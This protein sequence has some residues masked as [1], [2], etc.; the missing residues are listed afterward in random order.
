MTT[1]SNNTRQT[2]KS[3][4]SKRDEVLSI[5]GCKYFSAKQVEYFC[6]KEGKN[7]VV[8][9][10]CA[11]EDIEE[12]LLYQETVPSNKRY[13]YEVMGAKNPMYEVYDV[14]FDFEVYGRTS[15]ED[16]WKKFLDAYKIFTEYYNLNQ[17]CAWRIVDASS[18]KKVSLHI[19]NR[20]KCF[21]NREHMLKHLHAFRDVCK[22]KHIDIGIDW[23]TSSRTNGLMRIIGSSKYGQTRPLVRASFHPESVEA[24][25]RE[26]FITNI[27]RDC[28]FNKKLKPIFEEE[29]KFESSSQETIRPSLNYSEDF[30]QIV[31]KF[32]SENLGSENFTHSRVLDSKGFL[33]LIR[34]RPSQCFLRKEKR[35]HD[36]LGGYIWENKGCVYYGC[37]C[38]PLNS[39]GEKCKFLISSSSS[40]HDENRDENE[41]ENNT[42]TNST[43]N[44]STLK[45]NSNKNLIKNIL[46][47]TPIIFKFF[48]SQKSQLFKINS[49]FISKNIP[50]IEEYL[51]EYKFICFKSN[52]NTGKTYFLFTLFPKYEKILVITFRVSLIDSLFEKFENHGFVKYS[53]I[54]GNIRAKRLIVQVDSLHKV[55]LGSNYDLVIIDEAVYTMNHLVSFP[56]NKKE[57]YETLCDYLSTAG[58]VIVLD[59]LL[60]DSVVDFMKSFEKPLVVIEN[61]YKSFSDRNAVI[62]NN[63]NSQTFI[64]SVLEKVNLGLNICVPTNSKSIAEQLHSLL[65]NKQISVGLVTADTEKIPVSEWTKYQVLIYTP[66]IAAGISFEEKH[67]D[68]IICYFTNTSCP[69][70]IAAQMIFRVRNTS[71]NNISIFYN[72]KEP[73]TRVPVTEEEVYDQL[74]NDINC[75]YLDDS[76]D[77]GLIRK[78]KGVPDQFSITKNRSYFLTVNQ[79]INQNRSKLW[80]ELELKHYL[81]THGV[82][83]SIN[84]NFVKVKLKDHGINM[85]E[86]W[87]EYSESKSEEISNALPLTEEE[88][89]HISSKSTRTKDEIFQIKKHYIEKVYNVPVTKDLV[90]SLGDI[91]SLK[92]HTNFLK[93]NTDNID[94]L[95][96]YYEGKERMLVESEYGDTSSTD[97]KKMFVKHRN[98]YLK[99]SL[100]LQLISKMGFKS[101]TREEQL[102]IDVT[103]LKEFINNRSL[104]FKTAFDLRKLDFIEKNEDLFRFINYRLKSYSLKVSRCGKRMNQKHTLEIINRDI[105]NKFNIKFPHFVIPENKISVETDDKNTSSIEQLL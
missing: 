96:S 4:T 39:N 63:S 98:K 13:F 95:S 30:F 54:K 32:I 5:P 20:G 89:E 67:F 48:K 49:K 55:D 80:F 24:D 92:Q 3:W 2:M 19:V 44:T 82:K 6:L 75:S 64:S 36:N 25:T 37:H 15:A 78:R 1:L 85:K 41:D 16:V 14:D 103:S 77:C 29:K 38:S 11:F 74:V 72:R 68:E 83:V 100:V 34:K 18:D 97:N 99:N 8:Y 7:K 104:K 71:S 35:I 22:L 23:N 57:I 81:E 87:K 33:Q 60:N 12:F 47:F 61:E 76:G 51:E 101:L 73:G 31:E 79:I 53:D 105:K 88:F 43:T 91:K 84:N 62:Y 50:G 70:D 28:Y 90:S 46:Q 9:N 42:I 94:L 56:S 26:F 69:A 10:Y 59:A 66:T 27:T 17:E 40:I 93:I 58:K 52:M 86:I 65:V 21:L 102:K 45:Q